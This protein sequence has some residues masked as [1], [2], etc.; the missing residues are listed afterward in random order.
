MAILRRNPSESEGAP[1]WNHLS[2][3]Q[4]CNSLPFPCAAFSATASRGSR[5]KPA[6]LPSLWLLPGSVKQLPSSSR[7]KGIG[8]APVGIGS[9]GRTPFSP[10]FTSTFYLCSSPRRVVPRLT[11]SACS[12]AWGTFRKTTRSSMPRY[13]RKWLPLLRIRLTISSSCSTITRRSW[14]TT[15]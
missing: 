2:F 7:F 5:C 11:A 9:S 1:T 8:T 4:N 15:S 14:T 10:S 3:R 13:V 12:T 6:G